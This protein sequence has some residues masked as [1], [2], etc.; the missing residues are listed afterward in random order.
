MY[1]I[2]KPS[3][4]SLCI[5]IKVVKDLAMEMMDLA[6]LIHQINQFLKVVF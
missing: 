5:M 1:A 4:V 3:S 6:Q 2:I